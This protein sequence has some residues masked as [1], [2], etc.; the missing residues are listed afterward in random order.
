MEGLNG[1]TVQEFTWRNLGKQWIQEKNHG[2]IRI[3][4]VIPKT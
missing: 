3:V 2:N 4:S 1:D